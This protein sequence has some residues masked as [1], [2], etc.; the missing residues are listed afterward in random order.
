MTT[1][2]GPSST[3]AA[4]KAAEARRRDE[5]RRAAEA[6]QRE[7]AAQT[8]KVT[9]ENA[10]VADAPVAPA[11]ATTTPAAPDEAAK[12]PAL[13][14]TEVQATASVQ[15]EQGKKAAARLGAVATTSAA[16]PVPLRESTKDSTAALYAADADDAKAAT[17]ALSTTAPLSAQTTAALSPTA[18][19]ED[20]QGAAEQFTQS[21]GLKHLFGA[22]RD[23]AVD[24]NDVAA[25]RTLHQAE[26]LRPD[27][28]PEVKA[29]LERQ[30]TLGLR[31]AEEGKTPADRAVAKDTAND[32]TWNPSYSADTRR[33]AF[34][35][36]AK[37]E[38]LTDDRGQPKRDHVE[39]FAESAQTLL[40]ETQGEGNFA[41]E[42]RLRMQAARGVYE[43]AN[44]ASGE[45]KAALT[46]LGD[47]IT[48][49]RPS[50]PGERAI[51]AGLAD[52]TI[53]PSLLSR[54]DAE[55]AL[56]V[57][58]KYLPRNP[59][60][61]LGH[62]DPQNAL[63]SA[64]TEGLAR[65]DAT[66]ALKERTAELGALYDKNGWD[67]DSDL[68]PGKPPTAASPAADQAVVLDLV[69]RAKLNSPEGKPL[70][71]ASFSRVSPIDAKKGL[72]AI[73]NLKVANP[74]VFGDT[75]PSDPAALQT[76]ESILSTERA[77]ARHSAI[78]NLTLQVDGLEKGFDKV[79]DDRGVVGRF[80]DFS[81]NTFGSDV[82]S[83][84]VAGSVKAVAAE[85]QKLDALR[86]FEGSDADFDAAL[87]ARS[88]DLATSLKTAGE[89]IGRFQESQGVWVDTVSDIAA[90]TAGV[91]A[92]A[93][94]PVT[95]GAS[96]AL[97]GAV[98]AATKVST[99]ALDAVTGSGAYNGNVVGDAA[100][101]F[102]GGASGAGAL[103][104]S[105]LVGG[106]ITTA[107]GARQAAGLTGFLAGESA[108]GAVD[109]LVTGA[110]SSLLRGEDLATAATQGVKTA[111]LGVLIGPLVGGGVR[112]TSALVKAV[113]EGATPPARLPFDAAKDVVTAQLERQGV[114]LSSLGPINTTALPENATP[115][116]RVKHD[117]SIDVGLPVRA[118]GTISR[119]TL[120]HEA[121]HLRQISQARLT[122]DPAITE[123]LAAAQRQGAQVERLEKALSGATDPVTRARLTGELDQARG[124][125]ANNPLERQARAAGL[126]AEAQALAAQNPALA[127]KLRARATAL[128]EA[129][130]NTTPTT[131]MSPP[132]KANDAASPT[133]GLRLHENPN[134]VANELREI[135]R[136]DVDAIHAQL[137]VI[138]ERPA[139]NPKLTTAGKK[140]IDDLVM[141]GQR[142]QE[143]YPGAP[144]SALDRVAADAK[145]LGID[146]RSVLAEP[147]SSTI[148]APVGTAKQTVDSIRDAIG[149]PPTVKTSRSFTA[150]NRQEAEQ[151]LNAL[152]KENALA[153]S[154]GYN[155][156]IGR[157]AFDDNGIAA[158]HWDTTFTDAGILKG[159][160]QT[161]AEAQKLR[162]PAREESMKHANTPHLQLKFDALDIRIFFP[163]E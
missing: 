63:R 2:Q 38:G 20:R 7:T 58:E 148:A 53:N 18:S 83:D 93:A 78:Q 30:M 66:L 146:L 47:D 87:R 55:K 145:D 97:G 155:A 123:H 163:R 89:H 16:G 32:L 108:A 52:G 120:A 137:K 13:A 31:Q 147:P 156:Y 1:T 35:S 134:T 141:T 135:L 144:P 162:G 44:S 43:A 92:V 116:A 121:E 158:Y 73:Q 84:A 113:R 119:S 115:F 139:N 27:A 130:S 67:K 86:S 39:R 82:G 80:A 96:L 11:A 140:E 29:T 94:A 61:A 131:S 4:A 118:D 62:P 160:E 133:E 37:S 114:N 77:L 117:G 88:G 68:Q 81:K 65:R 159:H 41:T 149:N 85:R 48:R 6:A 42:N 143:V 128:Q 152:K 34:S 33:E 106:K 23:R 151:I 107:L 91:A 46:S 64:H 105:R 24:A 72:T 71:A 49:N 161:F 40:R 98:A 95:G 125:Y 21:F 132:P 50:D 28:S 129:P 110:G 90:V 70:D 101:G 126:N 74:D 36:W 54:N 136:G 150:A 142:R 157:T 109:G 99:K 26:T 111:A 12:K 127:E 9:D 17:P 14:A 103:H 138:N 75:P 154:S 5:A 124:A 69:D 10:V 59:M 100:V 51:V 3:D 56:A 22:D 104:L 57:M 112:G 79:L 60:M 25:A 45:R 76:R 122:G 153:D 8:Q 15:E 102:L 19:V